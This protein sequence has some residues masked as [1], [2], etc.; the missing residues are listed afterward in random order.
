MLP[1]IS[2]EFLE[3]LMKQRSVVEIEILSSDEAVAQV[4]LDESKAS[5][6]SDRQSRVTVWRLFIAKFQRTM[7]WFW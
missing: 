6:V 4:E 7:R 3:I 5:D 2:P 1:Y